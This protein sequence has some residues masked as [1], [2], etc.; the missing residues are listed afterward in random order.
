MSD[1]K[2][3]I[4]RTDLSGIHEHIDAMVDA[5]TPSES[6]SVLA[7]VLRSYLGGQLVTCDR[8]GGADMNFAE[9]HIHCGKHHHERGDVRPADP[10]P[11]EVRRM[12]GDL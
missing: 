3:P 4:V 2:N 8:H 7:S 6:A 5:A 12:G 9:L 1:I 11:I 10:N